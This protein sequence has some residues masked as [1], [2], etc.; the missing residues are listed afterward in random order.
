MTATGMYIN[1]FD[2]WYDVYVI[3]NEP[4]REPTMDEIATITQVIKYHTYQ[5]YDSIETLTSAITNYLNDMDIAC[6]DF[7]FKVVALRYKARKD[8]RERGEE[9]S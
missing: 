5:V 8:L 4:N 2:D 6:L 3:I 1:E 7:G 9:K